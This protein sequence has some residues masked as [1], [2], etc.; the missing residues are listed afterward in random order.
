MQVSV[1]PDLEGIVG[2]SLEA[3]SYGSPTDVIREALLLLQQRDAERHAMRERVLEE[4]AVGARAME[5]GEFREYD[6]LEELAS[7]IESEGR[8]IRIDRARGSA[9]R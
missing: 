5:R 9:G 6:D 1:T 8:S 3:G 7:K 4:I 2:N